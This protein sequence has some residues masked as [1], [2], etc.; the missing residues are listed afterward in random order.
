MDKCFE[1]ECF[2]PATAKI[3]DSLYCF[4]HYGV[5]KPTKAGTAR[6]PWRVSN[7]SAARVVT[8]RFTVLRPNW[9]AKVP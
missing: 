7:M 4:Q 9:N 8:G 5:Y 6:G 2:Q 1:F 3:G